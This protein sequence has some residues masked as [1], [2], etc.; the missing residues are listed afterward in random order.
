MIHYL[1]FYCRKINLFCEQPHQN[2]DCC[3]LVMVNDPHGYYK[4]N[5]W[6]PSDDRYS[7]WYSE[8]GKKWFEYNKNPSG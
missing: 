7:I 8:D 6:Y 1:Q 2:A 4:D 3:R 5:C